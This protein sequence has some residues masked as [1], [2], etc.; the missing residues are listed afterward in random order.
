MASVAILNSM[1]SQL[2]E[3][4]DAPPRE[5]LESVTPFYP[6]AIGEFEPRLGRR[7]AAR[8][9]FRSALALARNPDERRYLSQRVSEGTTTTPAGL[10][11]SNGQSAARLGCIVH[12]VRTIGPCDGGR[13]PGQRERC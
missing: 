1:V 2:P 12:R 5:T 7:E 11:L 10:P 6:A 8:E 4:A 9:R 13:I 3:G